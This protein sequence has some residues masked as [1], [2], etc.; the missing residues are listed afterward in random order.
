M[1]GCL[2]M[3]LHRLFRTKSFWVALVIGGCFVG[4]HILQV[5]LP[6]AQA[7][8]AVDN[9]RTNPM[10]FPF[11]ACMFFMGYDMYGWQGEILFRLMPLLTA[12][13]FA[14]SY[15][16]DISEGYIKNLQGKCRKEHYLIAKYMVTFLSG[17][18]IMTLPLILDILCCLAL[19]PAHQPVPIGVFGISFSYSSMFYEHTIL[20]ILMYL[21]VDFLI[22]GLYAV[23]VFL[24]TDFIANKY[25]LVI[26]PYICVTIWQLVLPILQIPGL[27]PIQLSNPSAGNAGVINS[28]LLLL[29]WLS[30]TFFVFFIRG[31][32]RDEV[33]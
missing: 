32:R 31:K 5:V 16:C 17:G 19:L 30:I 2:K 26:F 15:F 21:F 6:Y 7:N 24:G 25:L 27:D 20:F 22:G 9:I 8:R 3:E 33:V 4:S 14:N 23:T 28:F 11:S 10:Q 12:I 1:R 29:A 18:L 13:P